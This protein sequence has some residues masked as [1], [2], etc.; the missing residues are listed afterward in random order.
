MSQDHDDLKN[1]DRGDE[2]PP[3]DNPSPLDTA[4]KGTEDDDKDQ[5]TVETDA[6]DGEKGQKGPDT[7]AEDEEDKD[8]EDKDKEEKGEEEGGED[9]KRIR[10]PKSR[11]DEAMARARA[12]EEALKQQLAKYEQQEASSKKE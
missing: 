6:K 12:R 7:D 1:L 8:K 2:L 9:K 10:I 5:K 11:F 3:R 4:G